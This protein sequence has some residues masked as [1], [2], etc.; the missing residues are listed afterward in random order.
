[1]VAPLALRVADVP[2]QIVG[3]LTLTVGLA[4]TVMVAVFEVIQAPVPPVT[5]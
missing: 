3:E 4:F 2:E 1:M 5:V